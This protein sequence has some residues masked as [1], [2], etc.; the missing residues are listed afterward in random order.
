M[1]C[2]RGMGMAATAKGFV[3]MGVGIAILTKTKITNDQ[4]SKSLLGYRVIVSKAV[5]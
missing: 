3:Q 5:S 1:L 4:Y 2:G